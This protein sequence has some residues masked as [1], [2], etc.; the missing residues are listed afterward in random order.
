MADYYV[1]PKSAL[2][3]T[4]DAIKEKTGSEEEIEFTKDGFKD[5]VEAIETG[6][7]SLTLDERISVLNSL[8]TL[9]LPETVVLS[10]TIITKQIFQGNGR[11]EIKTVSGPNVMQAVSAPAV[12]SAGIFMNCTNLESASFPK[13][14]SVDGGSLDACFSGCTKL[15][16][17][18]APKA[19]F[20]A[21]AFTNCT[22][23]T[24]IVLQMQNVYSST[25]AGCTALETVDFISWTQLCRTMIF[26]KCSSLKAIILRGADRLTTLTQTYTSVFDGTPFVTENGSGTIYIPRVLYD[27]LGDKSSLDYKAQTNWAALDAAGHTN[28]LPIEGSIYETQYADGTPIE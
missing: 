22:S 14:D 1:V 7:D 19:Q 8:N 6:I 21:S 11:T 26:K 2:T 15:Q 12:S 13:L 5:A 18:Y 23:L 24:T 10:G 9:A 25:F 4:A 16:H 20:G 28:W 3:A 17:V 27:H